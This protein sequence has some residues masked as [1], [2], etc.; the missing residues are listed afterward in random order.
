MTSKRAY[1]SPLRQQAAARTRE[2]ILLRATELFAERGYGRV[3]VADIAAAAGVSPPTVFASLGSKGA[4]L[5]RIVEDAVAA[6]GYEESLRQVTALTTPGEVLVALAAG[7]RAGNEG[8]FAAHQA[9]HKALPVHE[10][11]DELWRRATGAYREALADAARHLHTLAPAPAGTARETADRLWYWF[12]PASW[13]TLVVENGWSWE[14]AE[15]FLGRTAT[16]TLI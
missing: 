1:V 11:A 15:E 3:A 9:L 16:A 14:R 13:R 4:I 12:G 6:S 10:D 5:N 7:T 2:V 8:Q